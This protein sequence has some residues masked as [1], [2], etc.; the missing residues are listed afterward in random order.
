MKLVTAKNGKVY[1]YYLIESKEVYIW[2]DLLRL[3]VVNI[4]DV[5][6]T[7]K[8]FNVLIPKKGL[9]QIGW[10]RINLNEMYTTGAIKDYEYACCGE[11][12]K[13]VRLSISKLLD[14]KVKYEQT[15]SPG[16]NSQGDTRTK[17]QDS[18]GG[19]RITGCGETKR[20]DHGL[21]GTK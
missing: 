17:L 7:M 12:D 2:I 10:E 14:L 15:V 5:P 4:T 11:I 20:Q 18:G 21:S 9:I 8:Y 1:D 13:L 6:L 16:R 19:I 3:E